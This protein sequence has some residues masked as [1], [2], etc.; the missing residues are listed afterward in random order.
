[1]AAAGNYSDVVGEW[2]DIDWYGSD[3]EEEDAVVLD[4]SKVKSFQQIDDE[5]TE[6]WIA[7]MK[8]KYGPDWEYDPS[9]SNLLLETFALEIQMC[10]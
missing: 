4:Q 6:R 10:D 8:K 1:M 2:R 7:K 9:K 5:R 3:E